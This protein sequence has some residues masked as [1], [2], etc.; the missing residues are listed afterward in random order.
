[1]LMIKCGSEYGGQASSKTGIFG[2]SQSRD[3]IRLE[4]Q[5][6]CLPILAMNLMNFQDEFMINN[7]MNRPYDEFSGCMPVFTLSLHQVIG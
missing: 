3:R 7:F 4:S 6:W 1:M 5:N 2:I